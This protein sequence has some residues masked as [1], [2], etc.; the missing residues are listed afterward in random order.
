M[1]NSQVELI[2][3]QI[4]PGKDESVQHC[5]R[6][7][8]VTALNEPSPTGTPAD[9]Y[10][11]VAPRRFVLAGAMFI[12]GT[13][14]G[15]F[16]LP[17]I[18]PV[19]STMFLVGI[20][21]LFGVR[22]SRALALATIM[23][24][25]YGNVGLRP[26]DPRKEANSSIRYFRPQAATETDWGTATRRRIS[27]FMQANL[28]AQNGSLLASM[29]LGNRAI[30]VDRSTRKAFR[31]SGL[32]HVLAASGFNLSILVASVYILCRILCIGAFLR[33]PVGIATMMLFIIIAGPSP[34]VERAFLMGTVI[35]LGDTLKRTAHLPAT[36]AF[37]VMV[38]LA[39]NPKD[40][41]DIGLQLS[42]LSTGGLVLCAQKMQRTATR[43]LQTIPT[44]LIGVLTSC[45]VAQAFVF[46]LQVFYFQQL[47][48]YF[49][50]ANTLAAPLLP[51]ISIAGFATTSAFILES[52][53]GSTAVS[54]VLAGLCY[55]PVQLF[56]QLVLAISCFPF[57]Q[58]ETHKPSM[59]IVCL[60]FISL[61]VAVHFSDSPFQS[62][63][64]GAFLACLIALTIN[65]FF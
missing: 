57:A 42:Y 34:S 54:S 32:S 44:F 3:E 65:L 1:H 63:F 25:G 31:R 9:H 16:H 62:W 21:P 46:P 24:L 22:P 15:A 19:L 38:S 5:R 43:A 30:K 47:N 60:Y 2:A 35:L 48:P 17:W 13:A 37:S 39:V 41:A 23:L 49:L 58:I 61:Y 11:L 64:R 56:R 45:C 20:V 4:Q 59:E 8:G 29:V 14:Y 52:S 7:E 50:L 55:W 26:E 33:L 6:A 51:A 28:G 36:L 40:I 18:L 53:V 12:L 10:W 27:H